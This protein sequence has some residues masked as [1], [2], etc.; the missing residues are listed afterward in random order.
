MQENYKILKINPAIKIIHIY[1]WYSKY[2]WNYVYYWK[3][4]L[5]I[6]NIPD[7]TQLRIKGYF[8]ECGCGAY[9]KYV[10]LWKDWKLYNLW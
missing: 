8:R 5:E 10:A 7:N 6:L 2:K 3:G 1:W 4:D 9:K